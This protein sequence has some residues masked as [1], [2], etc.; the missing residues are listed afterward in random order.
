M[1]LPLIMMKYSSKSQS[2]MNQVHYEPQKQT[3]LN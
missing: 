1:Q 3:E 2:A